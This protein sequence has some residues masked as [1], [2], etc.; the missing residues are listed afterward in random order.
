[1]IALAPE[2]EATIC[3]YAKRLRGAFLGPD[4]HAQTRSAR[5]KLE[6]LFELDEMLVV[7]IMFDLIGRHAR[8]D[9]SGEL[10]LAKRVTWTMIHR[11]M[12][13]RFDKGWIGHK[14]WQPRAIG[15]KLG[16]FKEKTSQEAELTRRRPRTEKR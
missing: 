9:A 11:E 1:M 12:K 4:T 3:Q 14:P 6:H 5:D 2:S 16:R 10:Y 8:I 15:K 7:G 13:R